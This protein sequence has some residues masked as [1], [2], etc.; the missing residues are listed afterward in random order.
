MGHFEPRVEELLVGDVRPSLRYL[1]ELRPVMME[2]PERP[3][4][5]EIAYYM[6][7]GVKTYEDLRYDITVL[8]Y[9]RLGRE[10][11]KTFGHY[12]NRA[13]NGRPY[14]EIYEVISGKAVFVLQKPAGP[15]IEDLI[16]VEVHE[17]ESIL[18]PPGY[19][20]VTVNPGEGTLI[21]ANLVCKLVRGDYSLF[22]RMRGA[23]VYLTVFGTLKNP[24]YSQVPAPRNADELV[25][26]KSLADMAE[27]PRIREF[28]RNP[29]DEP[30]F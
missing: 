8:P 29:S 21:Y 2:P 3:M 26:K 13:S 15:V 25:I 1:S 27:D 24:M 5:G 10:H 28:L 6:Y 7:R 30:P 19:G 14:P 17:G 20:H 9:R 12:H 11:V 4:D 23:A 22:R 18:V 16:V